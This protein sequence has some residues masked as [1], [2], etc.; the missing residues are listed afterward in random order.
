[1][2]DAEPLAIVALRS[3]SLAHDL[4]PDGDRVHVSAGFDSAFFPR[5]GV[6]VYAF[7]ETNASLFLVEH[8]FRGVNGSVF[9]ERSDGIEKIT[10]R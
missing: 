9:G 1:V 2:L 6:D 3:V 10:V 5:A 8:H 4:A 7:D